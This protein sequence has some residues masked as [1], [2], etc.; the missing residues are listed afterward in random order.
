MFDVEMTKHLAELSKLT[1]TEEELKK[2]TAEMTDIIA[3]MDRVKETDPTLETYAL[4]AVEYKDLRDDISRESLD[5]D[6]IVKNAKAVKDNA[7][8][9]PKVV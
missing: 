9:V 5:T 2:A 1:F 8:A 6:K 4:P 3:L 7:F